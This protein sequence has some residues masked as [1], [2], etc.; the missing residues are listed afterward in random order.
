M[1]D[2]SPGRIATELGDFVAMYMYGCTC[3]YDHGRRCLSSGRVDAVEE[4]PVT[5]CDFVQEQLIGL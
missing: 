2:L 1:G 4:V 3:S 5:G